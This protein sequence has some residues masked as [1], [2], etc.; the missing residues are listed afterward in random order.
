[1]REWLSSELCC[2]G[3]SRRFIISALYRAVTSEEHCSRERWTGRVSS[4]FRP[5][6]VSS[7]WQS[8]SGKFVWWR[9]YI[10]P[11]GNGVPAKQG[12]LR[13][14]GGV[15]GWSGECLG[16]V[17]RSFSVFSILGKFFKIRNCIVKY[18]FLYLLSK[19]E[20]VHCS[21][22]HWGIIWYFIT[23]ITKTNSSALYEETSILGLY[24]LQS[25]SEEIK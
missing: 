22:Y 14:P 20:N 1:M 19:R 16:C 18:I 24:H 15:Y 17:F 6:Q 5:M 10:L 13:L 11:R 25:Y 23:K 2:S 3:F 8:A 12:V 9:R 7:L 4:R 21:C